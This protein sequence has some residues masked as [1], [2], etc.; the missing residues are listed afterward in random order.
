MLR[1]QALLNKFYVA[2]LK[3]P[4]PPKKKE[5]RLE[6]INLVQFFDGL[7]SFQVSLIKCI[8]L[9]NKFTKM[10]STIYTVWRLVV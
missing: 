1:T 6:F 3:L 4:P 9:V 10:L 2:W 8:F 5:I 7:Y